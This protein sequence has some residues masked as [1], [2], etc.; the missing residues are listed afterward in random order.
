MRAVIDEKKMIE[1]AAAG[2]SV[3]AIAAQAG[4]KKSTVWNLLS[5][6]EMKQ[7]I[8]A[9]HQNLIKDSLETAILN[10]GFAIDKYQKGAVCKKID[11]H[12]VMHE[13]PDTQLRDHGYKASVKLSEAVGILPSQAQSV[14]I[15]QIYNDNRTEVPEIIG[16]ILAQIVDADSRCGSMLEDIVDVEV[17]DV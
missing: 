6:A 7:Q 10:L 3:R 2:H 17:Q 14:Y 5:K 16:K 4:G 8:E 11:V 15:Q 13:V 12:G 9:I 1:L